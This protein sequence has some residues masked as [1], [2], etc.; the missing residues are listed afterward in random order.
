MRE[1]IK[2][3]GFVEFVGLIICIN[4]HLICYITDIFFSP[5]IYLAV[6]LIT[7]WCGI[8]ALFVFIP[9]LDWLLEN[10]KS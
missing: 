3:I 1:K 5:T 2:I 6:F 4:A 9:L 10:K 7:L 8:L